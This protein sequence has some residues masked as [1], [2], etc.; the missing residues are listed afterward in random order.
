MLTTSEKTLWIGCADSRVPDAVITGAKP[1]DI[2]VHRNIAKYVLFL[3]IH[4]ESN[5]TDLTTLLTVS[6]LHLK[7][8]NVLS[9]LRY[10]VD[11]LGVE[12]G[13]FSLL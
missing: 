8:D 10:A 12:H 6:Q 9:V 11:Y 4:Y 1:G 3:I 13:A 7:D 2:F 5:D